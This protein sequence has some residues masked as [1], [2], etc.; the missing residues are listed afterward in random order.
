MKIKEKINKFIFGSEY[1]TFEEKSS[2]FWSISSFILLILFGNVFY[3]INHFFSKLFKDNNKT[4][5]GWILVTYIVFFIWVLIIKSIY[6]QELKEQRKY[7]EESKS[8][9]EFQK[10]KIIIL[11]EEV[12]EL[13]NYIQESIF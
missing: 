3:A 13:K 12:R 10:N 11:E 7:Y 8:L 4:I 6:K 1:P 2:F 5:S 9:N